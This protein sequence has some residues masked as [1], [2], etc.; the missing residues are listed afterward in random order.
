MKKKMMFLLFMI[1]S[2]SFISSGYAI[3]PLYWNS[4]NGESE[5]ILTNFEPNFLSGTF[6]HNRL[7]I[8]FKSVIRNEKRFFIISTMNGKTITSYKETD[9]KVITEYLD[10]YTL[11]ANKN[12]LAIFLKSLSDKNSKNS[13]TED[14]EKTLTISGDRN[15]FKNMLDLEEASIIPILSE[16]LGNRLGYTGKK[17]PASLAI[18][19][20]AISIAASKNIKLESSSK[21]CKPSELNNYGGNCFGLCGKGCNC[22]KWVCGDCEYNHPGCIC[23]DEACGRYGYYHPLCASHWW[24]PFFGCGGCN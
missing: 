12:M 21:K 20:F 1:C 13:I 8:S 3:E 17:Y 5:L 10:A 4:Q 11:T 14:T 24:I 18:H 6:Y 9:D 19:Y 7:G 22:W 2:L 15:T 16:V 23:H